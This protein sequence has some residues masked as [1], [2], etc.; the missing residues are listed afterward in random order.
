MTLQSLSCRREPA[1]ITLRPQ[2]L[3]GFV[4]A[5]F[6]GPGV[7]VA[8]VTLVVWLIVRPRSTAAQRVAVGVAAGYFSAT[9]FILPH[10]IGWILFTRGYEP[11]S[12][13][14][15]PPAAIAGAPLCGGA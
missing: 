1:R 7:A 4:N 14:D 12:R 5:V 6:T 11:F 15:P 10:T 3:T 13:G 8:L 2:D 9:I